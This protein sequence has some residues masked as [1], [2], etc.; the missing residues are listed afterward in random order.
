MATT[1]RSDLAQLYGAQA[2]TAAVRKQLAAQEADIQLREA[3]IALAAQGKQQAEIKELQTKAQDAAVKL[4]EAKVKEAELNLGYTKIVSPTDGYVT[5]KKIQ[6]GQ[7]VSSG[8]E[9]FAVVPLL[10]PDI[11]VTANFKETEL[12]D[13]R[14]GQPVK[15]AIDTYPGVTLKGK[16]ES[17]MAGS[18]AVFSLFPPENATGN[19]VKVV[20]R[21]PVRITLRWLTIGNLCRRFGSV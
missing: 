12:T 16:V 20:Q 18:G 19:F 21:I 5:V 14:P 2:S 15:M 8:Q 3:N 4:A 1:E 10:P 11:W 13:V 6:P 17:I 7:F 9:L